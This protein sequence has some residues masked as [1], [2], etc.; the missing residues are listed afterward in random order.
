MNGH[1]SGMPDRAP[2]K[3]DVKRVLD[4]HVVEV[5]ATAAD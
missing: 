5:G 3:R 1:Y 4:V 2:H